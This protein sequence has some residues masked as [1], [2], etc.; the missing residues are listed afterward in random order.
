MLDKLLAFLGV[1]AIHRTA[2]VAG[3][4]SNVVKAFDQEF[5]QDHNAKNAAIDTL[6]QLL[7]AH[8][9]IDPQVAPVAP[10]VVNA[11]VVAQ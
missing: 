2:M 7:L 11:P 8:K 3:V 4:A 10:P 1:G 9:V 6:V 5:A